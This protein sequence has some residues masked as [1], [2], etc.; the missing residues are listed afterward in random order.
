MLV[1][2]ET[3][4][5]GAPQERLAKLDALLR[6]VA[7][8][9]PGIA[10]HGALVAALIEAGELAQ[11]IADAAFDA[12][13]HDAPASAQD[14]AMAVLMRLAR[15]VW[16]SWQAGFD[17]G[18]PSPGLPSPDMLRALEAVPL[19]ER[20]T[21]RWAE[22]FA[23]YALYPEGYAM[24]AAASGLTA[25]TRVVGIRSIGAPLGAM[26]AAAL[27]APDPVTVRPTGH[28]F[29]RELAVSAPL[30]ARLHAGG[31]AAYAVVDEGPGL[32]GSSFGAVLDD[33]AARGVPPARIALFPSHPGPPGRQASARHRERWNGL[34]RH[35]TPFSERVL[36]AA[37]HAALAAWT[38]DLIG[39]LDAPLQD[40][41]GGAWRSHRYACEAEWPPANTGQERRKFLAR[42][43][44]EAWL[45]KF[46][47]LGPAAGRKLDRA[48]RLHAAGFT[49]APA[50]YR[51]GFLVERWMGQAQPL[52]RWMASAGGAAPA[53]LADT[54]GRYLGFRARAFGRDAAPGASLAD[55][56][57]MARHNVGEALGR[58]AARALDAWTPGRVA[59]LARRV[60][61]VEIDGRLHAWEWL[62]LPDG[63]LLKADA[64]DHHAGH[65]L[66]GCQDIAWDVAGATE[67]LPLDAGLRERLS[68]TVADHAGRRLDP[69]LVALLR[70]CY[71]AFQLGLHSMARDAAPDPGEAARLGRAVAR[72][73]DRLR[74]VL[75]RMGAD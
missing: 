50:G 32:S 2:G 39:P 1:Y 55:L 36:D 64:L 68:E 25:A 44:G 62:V 45:L 16:A 21:T 42:A 69:D 35:V 7:E 72:Y 11:G 37:G 38:A 14:A 24:A 4:W 3:A 61:P 60:H 5:T 47:G 26:V 9:A 28:P 46:A 22:G 63:R 20:I 12:R 75:A 71:L 13:G 70:P 65:D 19:P 57:A 56:L 23:H 33:L 67:E 34:A 41:S 31:P 18:M 10:R 58:D 43:Q 6:A 27:D 51:H 30:S 48:G 8:E 29:R 17:G 49:A 15:A 66:V 59:D 40:L 54:L 73:A 53:R 74:Q 52:D